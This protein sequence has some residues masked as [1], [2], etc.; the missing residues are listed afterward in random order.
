MT[1]A[2]WTDTLSDSNGN[3]SV[4]VSSI[5]QGISSNTAVS[6]AKTG[7]YTATSADGFIPVDGTA[8]GF[9]ITL[10]SPTTNSGKEYTIKRTDNTPANA[11]TVVATIDGVS[12]FALYTQYE[13][14]RVKSDGSGYNIVGRKASTEWAAYTPTFTGY[15]TVASVECQWRREGS[16]VLLR[17][18]WTMGTGTAVEAQITLPT[19]MTSAAVGVI[20]S[21]QICG[22][23]GVGAAT[24]DSLHAMIETSKAYLVTSRQSVSIFTKMNGNIYSAA[25]LMTIEARVP[26]TGWRV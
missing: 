22:T 18:K 10:P 17:L 9:N 19:S 11:V 25:S 20:P 23:M 2:V 13:M 4:A 21:I 24:G 12:N 14:L 15:G 3:N 16:E 6:T 26:I 7:N 1:S 8:G 5:S